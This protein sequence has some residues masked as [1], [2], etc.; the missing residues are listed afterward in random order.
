MSHITYCFFCC[1]DN[2]NFVYVNTLQKCAKYRI[3]N[4]TTSP[5]NTSRH[6]QHPKSS[7]LQ[8]ANKWTL[9]IQRKGPLYHRNVPFVNQGQL[10]SRN[11]TLAACEQSQEEE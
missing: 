11:V 7:E 9:A 2:Y 5:K 10:L 8:E 4:S 3:W 1:E 6:S